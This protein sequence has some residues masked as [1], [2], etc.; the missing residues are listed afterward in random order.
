MLKTK[1]LVLTLLL[2]PLKD[3]MEY[4]VSNKMLKKILFNNYKRTIKSLLN[5]SL[6]I[7]LK[8]ELQDLVDMKTLL[9]LE[10]MKDIFVLKK[11]GMMMF[12]KI[13]PLKKPELHPLILGLNKLILGKLEE[14][15]LTLLIMVK[16]ENHLLTCLIM[17]LI[18][19]L[20]LMLIG[21]MMLLLK[22]SL[23]YL[24]CLLTLL[25]LNHQVMDYMKCPGKWKTGLLLS[26]HSE[27][28][29]PNI[30]FLLQLIPL[31]IIILMILT[32][33]LQ[34]DILISELPLTKMLLF[35][36]DNGCNMF[37]LSLMPITIKFIYLM[38]ILPAL[39]LFSLIKPWCG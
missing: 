9:P 30:N 22:K 33:V 25:E 36:E 21:L 10:I 24:V 38:F 28:K 14:E 17:P 23:L 5:C 4:L 29:K 11:S 2:H 12:V 3:I 8:K 16:K 35:S 39:T 31:L 7:S 32:A 15:P 20:P 26:S 34:L 27:I 19:I 1:L 37:I 13:I 18:S 6:S